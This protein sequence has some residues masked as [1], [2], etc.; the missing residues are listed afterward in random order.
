MANNQDRAR[1]RNLQFSL[2]GIG[3][4]SS[5]LTLSLLGGTAALGAAATPP[6]CDATKSDSAMNSSLATYNGA[7]LAAYLKSPAAVKLAKDV[8]AKNKA[9][10]AA[11]AKNAKAKAKKALDDAKRKQAAAIEAFKKS[12]FF[13]S[14][15]ASATP[16]PVSRLNSD[17]L[18]SWGVYTT[19]VMVNKR[20]L[21]AVCTSVDESEAGNNLG[22]SATEEDKG[23]SPDSYQGP[24]KGMSETIPGQLPVLWYATLAKPARDASAVLAN[25]TQCITQDWGVT[26]APCIKGGL[27]DLS[28]LGGLTGATYTVN[29]YKSSLQGAL[30]LAVAAE[31]LVP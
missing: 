14:F 22:Q 19:R 27:A 7:K 24:D 21:T 18:W 2:M 12:N 26:T 11:K 29:G 3:A 8:A 17:G 1:R 30:D 23:V 6:A 20:A 10:K 4:V 9:Y 15:S 16:A 25:V 28:L 13:Y 31:Q 5:G